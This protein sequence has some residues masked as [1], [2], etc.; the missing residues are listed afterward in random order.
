MDKKYFYI[1]FVLFSILSFG[2]RV[3]ATEY[4]VVNDLTKIFKPT[5]YKKANAT[6]YFYSDSKYKCACL[7]A[8]NLKFWTSGDI[9]RIKGFAISNLYGK[10]GDCGN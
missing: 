6:C 2:L 4:Y 3:Y 8:N 1:F 5:E 7:S 9:S 10:I